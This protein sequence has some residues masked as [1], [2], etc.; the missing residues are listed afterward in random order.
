MGIPAARPSNGA[1]LAPSTSS[2]PKSGSQS[3]E[4]VC[5]LQEI[6]IVGHRDFGIA[7]AIAGTLPV[8][9]LPR[10]RFQ[11]LRLGVFWMRHVC[12]DGG[13]RRRDGSA[14]R[15]IAN[16]GEPPHLF[17][18]DAGSHA[19]STSALAILL[20][21]SARRMTGDSLWNGRILWSS[22]FFPARTMA[23]RREAEKWNSA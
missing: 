8:S 22:G 20:V 19:A 21:H 15:A 23:S 1:C 17:Q 12:F 13:R 3:P 11:V 10:R 4:E 6:A 14:G 7:G 5:L 9:F 16:A 18:S 2:S